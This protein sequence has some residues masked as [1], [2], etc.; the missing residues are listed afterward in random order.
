MA[1]VK[2]TNAHRDEILKRVLSHAFKAEA[3]KLR[4]EYAAF[5]GAVYD[6]VFSA[7]ERKQMEALPQGWL[8]VDE[9]IR[10]Q[11]GSDYPYLRFNGRHG[12]HGFDYVEYKSSAETSRRFPASK[13][14]T[15][16]KVYEAAHPM[17]VRYRELENARDDL[18][19]RVE[20][21]SAKTRAALNRAT[22]LARLV[23]GWP[24]IEPFTTFIPTDRP[25]LPAIQTDVLNGLLDLPV[26][27]NKDAA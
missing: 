26:A 14:G 25:A 13:R 11:I 4:D 16:C 10:V 9:D 5:A 24:E 2:L 19:Q 20:S 6:D 12:Y 1:S 22:T 17:T 7:S 21:A 23:E 27:E 8:P 3:E 15:T 18:R